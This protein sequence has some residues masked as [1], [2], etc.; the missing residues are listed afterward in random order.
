[1]LEARDFIPRAYQKPAIDFILD[2]PR[3]ALWADIGM[4]KTATVLSAYDYL[5]TAGYE[6]KPMLVLSTWRVAKSVWKEE[7]PKWLQLKH[8]TISTIVG[9]PEERRAAL[10]RSASV[11]TC[12]F[13]NLPWL[14]EELNDKWPFGMI[15][16]DESTRLKG[17]RMSVQTS[18]TG[19]KFL[20]GQGTLRAKLLSKIAFYS[21]E[22]RWVNLTGTPSSNGLLNLW[23]Q[24]WYQDFGKRLGNTYTAFCGRWFDAGYDGYSLT[25]KANAEKEIQDL[26]KDICYSILAEDYLDLE[27]PIPVPIYV[28]LPPA[29]RK[30]YKEMEKELFIKLGSRSAEAVNSAVK[31]GKC[32]QLANG[33][34]YLDRQAED[35][36]KAPKDWREVHDVKI[37][38]LKSI[39][40]E[41][42]GATLIIAYQ[43]QSDLERLK[44]AFP[45]GRVL[46]TKKDEDDF[47][48]GKINPLFAHPASAGHGID[49]FQNVCHRIVFFGHWWDNELRQQIIGRIG[50]VRQFQA[51]FKRPVY[52]YDIIARDTVDED[53]M[54]RHGSNMSVEDC[55]KRAMRRRQA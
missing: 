6:T 51:G 15:V 16:A 2:T 13:E 11:Y 27:K 21:K 24:S 19:K 8:I 9:T 22:E 48:A 47:K 50:P 54:F 34:V 43:F 29:A 40:E 33:A 14:I 55:L 39:V 31:S 10:R 53:V 35:N 23:G 32:L 37:D 44:K 45:K 52:I 18:K 49:G 25:P 26:L 5:F 28:D 30:L 17:L 41:S 46:K 36:P 38:A 20:R 3:C 42:D 1:M 12:N 4:G 7:P